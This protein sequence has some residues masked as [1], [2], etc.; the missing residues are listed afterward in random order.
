MAV[1]CPLSA[2]LGLFRL[3]GLRSTDDLGGDLDGSLRG[4]SDDRE[5]LGAGVLNC[6]DGVVGGL[7]RCL[8][9]GRC[10]LLGVFDHTGTLIVGLEGCRVSALISL[11]IDVSGEVSVQAC[12]KGVQ[13]SS[14]LKAV[15]EV[16][17]SGGSIPP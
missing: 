12:G 4:V 11:V 3:F 2:T 7:G 13:L 9:D 6:F 14:Y 16:A 10:Q 1:G 17:Q 15:R 8:E 5:G